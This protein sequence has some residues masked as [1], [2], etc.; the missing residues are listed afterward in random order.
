[1]TQITSIQFRLITGNVDGAST[2]G[3]V[4]LGVC[5]REF[6]VDSSANDFQQGSSRLYIFGVGANVLNPANNDPRKQSLQI[7]S[8]D[9]FPVYLRFQPQSRSDNWNVQR[10]EVSF[11]GNFFPRWDTASFVSQRTGIWMGTRSGL[12]LH[13]PRHQDGPSVAEAEQPE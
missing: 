2:D 8:V 10:A 1:M 6:Y 11:N 13:I 9:N 3:D 12:F 5:G 4:Y 7:E